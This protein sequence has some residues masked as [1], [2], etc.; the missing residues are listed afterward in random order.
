MRFCSW[1]KRRGRF[2]NLRVPEATGA[3]ERVYEQLEYLHVWATGQK[4]VSKI[5]SKNP[6]IL[7]NRDLCRE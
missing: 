4:T 7:E 1:K 2:S 5:L 3:E 6:S